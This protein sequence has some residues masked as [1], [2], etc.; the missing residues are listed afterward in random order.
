MNST[1]LLKSY[2]TLI[3]IFAF[4]TRTF[5]QNNECGFTYTPEAKR[6]FD[7]IKNTVRVLEEQ[8]LQQRLSSRNSMSSNSFPIKAHIIRQTNGSGGLTVTELN[9]AIA[10]MNTIYA[11]AGLEFYLCDGINYINSDNFYTYETNDESALFAAYSVANIMNIFFTDSIISSSSGG[12]L[13]GYAR[14]PGGAITENILMAN[15]CATNGST[16]SHEV[17]H[18]F[19]LSHTHGNSNVVGSTEELV[20]GSNCTST[21]DFI[22]DTPADPQL[23][24]SNV[25]FNCLYTGAAQDANNDSYQPEPLN[26]MSYSRKECRTLFSPQ[27]LARINAIY[28]ASRNNLICPSFSADFVAD[29]TESC[30]TNLTVNFTDS[31]AGATSWDW[32]VDGDNITDYTTQNVTHNYNTVGEYDVTLA[33]SDGSNTITKVKS[34]YINVGAQEINTT[35]IHLSLTL[36]NWPAE[37]SWQFLDGDDNVIDSGGP[38]I[39]PD[40]DYATKTAQFT[41]NPD[42]CY[43][44]VITDSYGDGI[45]CSSGSGSYE[46]TAVDLTLLAR[47]GSYNFGTKNRFFS[48]TLGTDDFSKESI[49]LF[50]NPSSSIIT[51]KSNSLPDSYSIYNT[52]GQV[53]RTSQ[54]KSD[55]DLNVNIES[56]NDGIYFIK[57]IKDNSSQVLSFIKN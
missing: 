19:A 27:Q 57:L 50:P 37:T 40:D 11:D 9:D 49:V 28:Q 56:L 13:C 10:V 45:C 20:D 21:G 41:I 25:D 30:A 35:E 31:S 32:D 3:L 18:F 51:I 46:L 8:F 26:L 44:F 38:Y 52:L 17:G 7:S 34:E 2:F 4:S 16:L 36:D 23:G 22:C 47:G 24:Y 12:G 33:V 39:E 1:K 14:F 6:Y 55:A 15:S 54:V 42:L 43:S 53:L 29:E 48:G 5:A